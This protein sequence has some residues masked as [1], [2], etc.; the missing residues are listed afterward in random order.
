MITEENSAKFSLRFSWVLAASF[1]FSARI[2]PFSFRQRPRGWTARGQGEFYAG[3]P[4]G[5]RAALQGDAPLVG[6]RQTAG[7]AG[8]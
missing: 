7:G 5:A 3:G 8:R 1:L 6:A 4:S 2:S